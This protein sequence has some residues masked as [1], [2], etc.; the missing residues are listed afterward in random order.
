MQ[1]RTVVNVTSPSL[2]VL[3][4]HLADF[5]DTP[6]L[7]FTLVDLQGLVPNLLYERNSIALVH[8]DLPLAYTEYTPSSLQIVGDGLG[9]GDGFGLGLDDGLGDGDGLG[10]GDGLG[11]GL[12]LGDGLGDGDGF[13]V[14]LGMGDTCLVTAP[15]KVNKD[16]SKDIMVSCTRPCRVTHAE[17]QEG[18]KHNA[19][20][21]THRCPNCRH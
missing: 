14:G 7:N 16:P 1:S 11:L 6:F 17:Q 15:Q 18:T 2:F 9:D 19:D 21:N 12:G 3:A 10:N 4:I 8:L 20:I 13:G 5:A